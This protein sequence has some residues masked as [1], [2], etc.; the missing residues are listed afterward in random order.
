MATWAQLVAFMVNEYEI[1]GE[2]P[3]EVRI[4]IRYHA[5]D[6]DVAERSQVVSVTREVMDGR[7]EWVQIASPFAKAGQVD[8]RA[9]L[10]EVGHTTV[11]GGVALV[12][13]YVVLR[14][15]LPL[16]NLDI[17]EFVDPLALVAGSAE[18]L[19]QHFIGRDEF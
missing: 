16:V 1:L 15:S 14:H 7:A 11:V 17:N 19:E 13:E 4:L 5:S 8:L 10:A 18:I 9:V 6:D 12:G 2:E 3:D